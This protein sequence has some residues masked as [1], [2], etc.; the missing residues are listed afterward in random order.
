MRALY[1]VLA[2]STTVGLGIPCIAQAVDLAV[3]AKIDEIKVYQE[4]ATVT[5]RS[6]VSIPA[7]THRLV[8]KDLPANL[9]TDTLRISVASRDVRLGGIEVERITD[10]DYVGTQERELRERL[11]TLAD[12]RTAIQDEIATAET[13]LKLLDSLATAPAGGNTKAAVDA[14]NLSAVL[15]TM[16]TS[17]AAAREKVRTAR[18]RQRD[19]DKE[20]E[21]TNAD[22]QKIAT[23]RKQSYE[24]RASIEAAAAATPVVAI[25]YS[26]DDAGWRWVYEARLDTVSKRVTIGRQASVEQSSGET[27]QNAALTLTTARPAED[28]MTPQLAS[29]FLDLEEVRKRESFLTPQAAPPD[30]AQEV[31][32][33]GQMRRADL[34]ATEYLAD[35]RIP[36]R[37]TLESDGEPRLY[38]VASEEVAVELTARVIPAASRSAYLEALFTFKGEVPM[39]GGEVQLYRDGAFVGVAAIDSLLPGAKARIPF[40]VDER[41]R[42]V[43]RDEPK[44]SGDKGLIGRQRIEEHKQRVEVTNYHAVPV[45]IEVIDRVPVTEN[46]DVRVE[47]LKGATSPTQEDLD[48]KSGVMLWRSVTQPQQTTTVRHYYAVRYPADRELARREQDD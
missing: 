38:P 4:G 27:W 33:T 47:I 11:Q 41:V 42:V 48:G 36:G 45:T 31:V 28:A 44:Q 16:S 32:V 34:I 29:L 22:L 17:A 24:V 7:G 1:R 19:L 30:S 10:K 46:K 39:Q 20:I 15:N 25:E 8:F 3:D 37:V 9:D 35:Y 40:G 43:V 18:I 23:A 13:Q 5:R 21:K 12:R 14:T 6:Q 2:A 26:T